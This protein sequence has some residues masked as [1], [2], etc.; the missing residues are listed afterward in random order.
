MEK[1][2]QILSSKGRPRALS[3]E[4]RCCGF[5]V[6]DEWNLGTSAL[7]TGIS[8]KDFLPDTNQS[9]G[10]WNLQSLGLQAGKGLHFTESQN[11]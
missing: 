8:T 4:W 6:E 3:W 9:G 7:K 1:S 10:S 11:F 2:S 5:G